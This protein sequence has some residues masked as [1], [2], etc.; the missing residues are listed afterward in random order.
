M[1]FQSVFTHSTDLPKKT[2]FMLSRARTSLMPSTLVLKPATTSTFSGLMTSVPGTPTGALDDTTP[3]HTLTQWKHKANQ[4]HTYVYTHWCT[5]TFKHMYTHT[6]T[7]THCQV[8]YK[9]TH[10]LTLTCMHTLMHTHTHTPTVTHPHKTKSSSMV[11]KQASDNI[12]VENIFFTVV[13][14]RDNWTT[15]TQSKPTHFA[16]TDLLPLHSS[17]CP[18]KSHWCASLPV[19]KAAALTRVHDRCQG[20]VD[21]W[22][23]ADLGQLNPCLLGWLNRTL[24]LPLPGS[25]KKETEIHQKWNNYNIKKQ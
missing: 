16:Q 14:H 17:R 24:L 12:K 1:G 20:Y 2:T 3:V 8:S 15:R 9:H 4:S 10:S 11:F 22:G 19:Q 23:P 7:L 21:C 13:N 6:H 25:T 18:W 5:R